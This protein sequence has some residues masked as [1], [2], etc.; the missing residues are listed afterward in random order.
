MIAAPGVRDLEIERHAAQ[1]GRLIAFLLEVRTDVERQPIHAGDEWG[2]QQ[3]ADA[4]VRV[5]LARAL[6]LGALASLE[7]PQRHGDA[8]G[9]FAARGI[10][11]VR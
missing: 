10:E 2:V 5:G 8:G 6:R 4:P 11:D 3:I 9:G 7:T 1:K